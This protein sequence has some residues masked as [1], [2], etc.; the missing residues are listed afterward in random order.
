MPNDESQ[1]LCSKHYED[2]TAD[3]PLNI[4][5]C[6]RY[7]KDYS[8]YRWHLDG[9]MQRG[10]DSFI[11]MIFYLNDLNGEGGTCF[12]D[13]KIN[14]TLGRVVVF[15]S[16]WYMNHRSLCC[17]NRDKYIVNVIIDKTK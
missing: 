14:G 6:K 13:G 3:L 2:K 4:L 9:G 8:Y 16:C 1:S 5:R 10:R 11:S 15:P 17:E 7:N 12:I